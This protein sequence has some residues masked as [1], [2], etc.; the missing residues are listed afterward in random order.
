MAAFS[1]LAEKV[2]AKNSAALAV[3]TAVS[4]TV[5]RKV[6]LENKDK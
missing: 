6:I 4:W 5:L 2:T 3:I 1:K